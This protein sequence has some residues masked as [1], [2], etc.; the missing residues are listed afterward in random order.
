MKVTFT[1]EY[2]DLLE[3]IEKMLSMNGVQAL[4]EANGNKQVYF[5]HKKKEIVV[6]C[7][8]APLPESCPFCGSGVHPEA[9]GQA[10]PQIDEDTK[11]NED[12]QA[13]EDT[14]ANTDDS[15]ENTPMSL[16]ALRAQSS[17]LAAQKPPFKTRVTPG[18]EAHA[19]LAQ[20]ATL[21]GESNEPP[22]PGEGGF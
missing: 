19:A 13:N 16:S 21:D 6:H 1:F 5:D 15:E 4:K 14:Q 20:P 10:D 18:A 8:A 7:E 11:A 2:A 22:E 3:Q 17:A 12:P 9:Q